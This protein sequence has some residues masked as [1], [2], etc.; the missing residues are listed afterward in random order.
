MARPVLALVLFGCLIVGGLAQCNPE[1][2]TQGEPGAGC[3]K[4]RR[5]NC[6]T[7]MCTWH[8]RAVLLLQAHA[9]IH[10]AYLFLPSCLRNQDDQAHSEKPN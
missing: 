5:L 10:A 1:T 6:H 4:Q 7:G 2:S 8:T 9:C 3:G